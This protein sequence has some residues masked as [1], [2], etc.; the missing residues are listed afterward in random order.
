MADELNFAPVESDDERQSREEYEREI[1]E[2]CCQHEPFKDDKH[3]QVRYLRLSIEEGS[4]YLRCPECGKSPYWWD[5]WEISVDLSE[6][7]VLAVLTSDPGGYPD[8]EPD[9]PYITLTT[10]EE[11]K[12]N[13]PNTAPHAPHTWLLEN[14]IGASCPGVPEPTPQ[15][16]TK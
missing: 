8:Y 3:S 10:Q 16:S 1:R 9:G 14:R 11:N 4:I 2:A 7:P 5:D 12:V 13:C 6:I 15:P